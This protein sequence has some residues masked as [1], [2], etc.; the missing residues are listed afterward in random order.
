MLNIRDLQYSIGTRTLFKGLNWV[1]QAG[2]RAA[3]IG[4]NGAGKTTLFKIIHSDLKPKDGRILKPR[5]YKIGYLPQEEVSFDK[6]TVLEVAL[7]GRQDVLDLADTIADLRRR[8]QR[9]TDNRDQLLEKLGQTE[10]LFESLEGYKLESRAKSVLSGLGF[11]DTH[12]TRPLVELSGGWRMRVYL[13]RILLQDPDLL[14]LDEPTNHL[15]LP[16]LEWLEGY[17]QSFPGSIIIVSHD[18]FFIDMIADEIYELSDGL[19]EHY[20]GNYAFYQT[21]REKRIELLRKK[22]EEQQAEIEKQHRFI[23]RFRYKATKAVQVQSRIK[24]LEKIEQIQ[25]PDPPKKL[26]FQLAVFKPGYKHVLKMENMSFRYDKDWVLWNINL[27]IYR[28][29]KIAL[30][31]VNGAGKTTMTRLM[32]GELIP[33][34]GSVSL[35]PRTVAGYYAQH[36]VDAL[37]LNATVYDE[38]ASTVADEYASHIRTILG[39]FQLSGDDVFKKIAVLSGGE[40]ARVSLAK[41]ILSPVNF[42]IMDEPTNH[43]DVASREALEHALK[44]FNGTCVLISHDRYF[45]DRLVTRVFEVRD[46]QIREFEGNYSDYLAKREAE[47][48]IAR[49]PDAPVKS[50]RSK[51]QKRREAEARQAV[52]RQRNALKEAIHRLEST[53]EELER[54]KDQLETLLAD[55]QTYK[56]NEKAAKAQKSYK[57]IQTDLPAALADWEKKNIELENLMAG[58]ESDANGI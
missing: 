45:L 3:L 52:S 57:K 37:D 33:Q 10:H 36:Q 11:S 25:L 58:L 20:A 30:V 14:L 54:E 29:E 56:D 21:E 4:P 2:K 8:V 26:D 38:V 19:L 55:P 51:D 6:G 23:D 42:L 35:G 15:D 43:L 9:K 1:I 34:Q 24:K 31:G 5:N 46:H 32:V 53:I 16:S 28:G 17:L 49:R 22:Y 50:K 27:D 40:K 48:K 44:T 39:V 13:A 41:I 18:R 47:I 12:F 7:Q